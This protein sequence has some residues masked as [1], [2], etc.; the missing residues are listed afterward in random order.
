M[1]DA[2]DFIV[3]VPGYMGSKLRDRRTGQ[4]VWLDV[5]A[6]LSDLDQLEPRLKALFAAM[7]YPNPNLEPAGLTDQIVFLPPFLKQEHY[8]RL[9]EALEGFGC[10]PVDHPLPGKIPVHTFAYD[11]RQDNRLSARQLAAAVHGW[12]GQHNGGK[13]WLIAHSNGGIVSRWYIEKENGKNDVSHLALM[14]SPWDGSPVSMQTMMEGFDMFI[15]HLLE[16]YIDVSSMM[17]AAV[18]TFPSFYQIVP[19]RTNFLRSARGVLINPHQNTRWLQNDQQ[20]ALLADAKKF[21]QD[22]GMELSVP[23]TCFI[24]VQKPTTTHGVVQFG[25]GGC[26]QAVKWLTDTEGD[27]TVPQ[28]SATHPN[29]GQ[30][31]TLIAGHGDVYVAAPALRW[32]RHE[33]S[34]APAALE[35]LEVVA[36]RRGMR[37]E[38]DCE[39]AVRRGETLHLWATLADEET[40]AP[41]RRARIESRLAL[42]QALRSPAKSILPAP[43]PAPRMRLL[44]E[45][46]TPGRY[47]CAVRAPS[48]PGYYRLTARI[49]IEGAPIEVEELVLVDL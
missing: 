32:L 8:G 16:A 39:D 29:A 12:R 10:S 7:H 35:G 23:S 24:G 15:T 1:M 21:N 33:L 34:L 46:P 2:N 27:G 28:H 22:L 42:V 47:E 5:P 31:I 11:W 48:L 19:W 3:I 41:V 43:A 4:I 9:F 45:T 6:L 14:A 49:F 20:R 17:R 25:P 30:K 13:A 44:K 40:G 36:I 37:I 26:W 18:L 38:F